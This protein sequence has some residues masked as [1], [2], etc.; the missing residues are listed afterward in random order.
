M[1]ARRI[2]YDVTDLA[3]TRRR[4]QFNVIY[5]TGEK[6][7]LGTGD[8]RNAG[9][10]GV[11]VNT[12][13]PMN[14][15]SFGQFITRNGH[16]QLK[17]CGSIPALI[18]FVIYVPISN[19]DEEEFKAFYMDLEK[20]YREDHT[21]FK[22]IIGVVNAK[23]GPRRASV[24]RH[25]WT[26]GLEW[27]EQDNMGEKIDGRQL[28]HFHFADDIVLMTPN[29]SQAERILAEF[30]KAWEKI[31]LCLNLTKTMFM[32]SGLVS[33]PPFM[34]NGTKISDCFSYLYLGWKST[35]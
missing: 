8:S 33:Y 26:H 10:V 35:C 18:I 32:S 20:F 24:E 29:I 25:I 16:L 1:Q 27:N 2:R 3:E 34:L 31:G 22:V 4:H 5:D 30:D 6:L 15:D 23:T 7:C 17:R 14:I 21:F 9:V 19:Y 12:S 11:L 13:L 28:H